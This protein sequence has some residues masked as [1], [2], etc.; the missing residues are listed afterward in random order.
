[1]EVRMR[2]RVVLG[3]DFGGSKTAAAVTDTSG[4]RLGEVVTPV[5]PD[6]SADETFARGIAAAQDLLREAAA[7]HE[8]AAV[9][10]CTFGIPHDDRVDLAP[11]IAGWERLAFGAGLRG[12]FPGAEVRIATDVKAAASAEVAHGA[13]AGCDPGLYINLGTGFA[14]AIVVGGVVLSG[15]HAAAG[16][17]GYN[18]RSTAHPPRRAGRLEDVV[19]GTALET[20]ARRLIG[21]P[22]VGALFEQGGTN[23]AVAEVCAQF[24]AE[25]CFHL[26]NLTIAIDPQ[27]LVVGGGLVRSWDRFGPALTRAI[28]DSVPFPPDVVPAAH[29][30]DAPLI[31]ALALGLSAV[32]DYPTVTAVLSEGAPA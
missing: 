3:L 20:A 17:I 29:P 13:L 22:D 30:F 6:A 18:L 1:M 23:R 10:A 11:N 9:G 8:L 32:P 26:V 2:S 5:D 24:V 27:R 19:S 16:E 25:L 4:A 12:T 21:R 28:S 7:G 31:G 15:R 14:V